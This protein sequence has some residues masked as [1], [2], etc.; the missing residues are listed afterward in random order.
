MQELAWITAKQYPS[1]TG[2]VLTQKTTLQKAMD[3]CGLQ[4]KAWTVTE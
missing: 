4:I 3:Y 2:R 1:E